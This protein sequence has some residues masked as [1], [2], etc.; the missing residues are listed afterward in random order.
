MK[1]KFK[2]IPEFKNEDEERD[3]WAK[4][5]EVIFPNL[6]RSSSVRVSIPSTAVVGLC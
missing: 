1:K 3:F 2:P 5:G 4:V 6:R